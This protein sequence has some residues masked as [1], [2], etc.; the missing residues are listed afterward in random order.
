[1]L[2]YDR[3]FPF[4]T[5]TSFSNKNPLHDKISNTIINEDVSESDSRNTD[6]ASYSSDVS[7]TEEEQTNS[8]L[9]KINTIKGR[10]AKKLDKINNKNTENKIYI[11]HSETIQNMV[12]FSC[13]I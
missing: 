10:K 4:F 13:K 5:Q 11:R 7:T 3:Y 8:K 9:D 12:I 6:D 1:M 2:I